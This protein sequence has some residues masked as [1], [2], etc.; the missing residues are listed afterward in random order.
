MT[1]LQAQFSSQRLWWH[2]T[3]AN[4]AAAAQESGSVEAEEEEVGLVTEVEGLEVASGEE[5]V[6]KRP[7]VARE[8]GL[9]MAMAVAVA[10][11]TVAASTRRMAKLKMMHDGRSWPKS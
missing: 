10:A 11:M 8:V 4:A 7:M 6:M 5:G 3:G 2:Q 9:V 1:S